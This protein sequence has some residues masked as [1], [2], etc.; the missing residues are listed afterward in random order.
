MQV[1]PKWVIDLLTA[2]IE[3]QRSMIPQNV[4]LDGVHNLRP[5]FFARE[6]A[7]LMTT[8]SSLGSSAVVMRWGRLAVRL[9]WR[10][11]QVRLLLVMMV[12]MRLMLEGL[13]EVEGERL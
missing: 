12:M 11:V 10:T 1:A 13:K 3:I 7:S 6:T 8:W 9:D 4:C 2:Y 5:N